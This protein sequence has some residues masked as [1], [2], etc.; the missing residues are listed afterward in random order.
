MPNIGNVKSRV[1]NPRFVR[2][3]LKQTDDN[4]TILLALV[5]TSFVDMAFN[6][7]ITSIKPCGINNYLFVGVSTAACDYLRRK[8]ISCYTY[9]EDSDADVESAF[10]SPA[11]LRKTNLR[12]EMILDALLAGITVLQTDVDVIFRKNPFPEMLLLY[13]DISVLWD[14]S[15]INAGFLLIRANERTVWIY[16]QVKKKTRRYTMN[17]QIALDYT[18]N[19]CSVYKYCRVTVLETSRF[20]NGKSYFE[21]GHRIF[22]GDNPC[23]NCVVIHNNY[24]VSKSAKVY[25]FKENHMWYNNENE[26]YTSQKNNYITFDMSEAFTFEEQRKALANA[27]A[28]GQILRRIVIL[29]K[30]RC[31]NGV[32]LCAMNSLFKISKFDRFFLNRYRESTFLSHPQ[33]PSEVTISTKQ[34]SLRNITVITS[35]NIIQYFGVEESRVLFLQSPQKIDIRFSNIREDDNFWRNVEMALMPCDYRQFC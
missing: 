14:Y 3:L 2:E 24:I 7:Y 13:S 29:P 8:G 33:V 28:F 21:D 4:F 16:D 32:K 26:Y 25:R 10:N 12:T 22:S 31:E 9:I 11:F 23:T 17:D 18:V 30:F 15:N 20:Q 1:S 34:V 27:L 35:N 6:F 5:D 19:A